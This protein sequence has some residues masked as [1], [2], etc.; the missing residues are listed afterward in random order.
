DL[1]RVTR[2]QDVNLDITLDPRPESLG[3]D[4]LRRP[5][6]SLNVRSIRQNRHARPI[7][8]KHAISEARLHHCHENAAWNEVV[9]EEDP[10]NFLLELCPLGRKPGRH[11]DPTVPDVPT[12]SV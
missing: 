10:M 11:E 5:R 2:N 8:R 9:F 3:E 12:R 6:A 1:G 4:V 7:P